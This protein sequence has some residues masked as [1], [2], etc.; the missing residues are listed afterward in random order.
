MDMRPASRRRRVRSGRASAQPSAWPSVSA[1]QCALRRRHRRSLHLCHRGRRLPDGRDQPRGDRSRRPFAGS[2]SSSCS[3]TTITSPST[4][5]TGSRPRPIRVLRFEASGW[6]V[7]NVDGHDRGAIAAGL[8]AGKTSGS[9]VDD[10]LLHGHR[11]GAHAERGTAGS[12]RRAIRATTG[13]PAHA[14]R[15]ARLAAG[16]GSGRPCS[17]AGA[18]PARGA[19]APAAAGWRSW[20]LTEQ[21]GGVQRRV[22]QATSPQAFVGLACSAKLVAERPPLATRILRH[23]PRRDHR[24]DAGG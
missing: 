17:R 6:H 2:A 7:Q 22:M 12:A 16:R 4:A 1:S 13:R 23:R 19:L 3:G 9:S 18:P 20:G 11:L 8:A 5:P 15:S 14:R 24:R 10:R 21:A